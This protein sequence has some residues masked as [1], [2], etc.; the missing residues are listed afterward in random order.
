MNTARCGVTRPLEQVHAKTYPKG[1][2]KNYPLC[3]LS[4]GWVWLGLSIAAFAQEPVLMKAANQAPEFASQHITQNP[5]QRSVMVVLT[6]D[7]KGWVWRG[8]VHPHRRAGGFALLTA[9][10]KRLRKAH[11]DLILLDGGDFLGDAPETEY[12][13]HQGQLPL[14]IEMMQALGY[15]A[16]VLGNRDLARLRLFP[17]WRQQSRVPWLAGNVRAYALSR[18]SPAIAALPFASYVLLNRAG[19]RI[20][21]VGFTQP[22][23]RHRVQ[24]QATQWIASSALPKAAQLVKRMRTQQQ[25]DVVI[26]LIHS[27]VHGH[28][29]REA[30]LR[31]GKA[32]PAEAGLLAWQRSA[33]PQAR[34]D[35]LISAAAHRLHPRARRGWIRPHADYPVPLVEAGAYASQLVMVHIG[36]RRYASP[37]VRTAV[38]S[39][40][41]ASTTAWR[42]MQVKAKALALKLNPTQTVL[43]QVPKPLRAR[44]QRTWRW[45]NTPTAWKIARRPNKR[46]FWACLGGLRHRAVLRLLEAQHPN[47]TATQPATTSPALFT[48]NTLTLLPIPYWLPRAFP[49]NERGLALARKHLYRWMPYPIQ[50][51]KQPIRLDQLRFLVQPYTELLQ[52]THRIALQKVGFIPAGPGLWYSPAKDIRT[53]PK[54]LW[55]KLDTDI[56]PQ[57]STLLPVVTNHH[58]WRGVHGL[59]SRAWLPSP[60]PAQ[61]VHGSLRE[62][63]FHTLRQAKS[64]PNPCHTWLKR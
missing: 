6:G 47:A 59:A 22:G 9:P 25:A 7:V 20:A 26:G 40:T 60:I 35:V 39:K 8:A 21:I 23:Q 63:M 5:K 10:L 13:Q 57:A 34:F 31:Q 24:G 2:R 36:L 27:G 16:A 56:A 29:G 28:Y 54:A 12:A 44:L 18:P 51:I 42:V 62:A 45:L 41:P 58:L 48:Q 43:S 17:H 4:A 14:A 46:T 53:H 50:L 49:K 32:Q 30:S 64:L 61:F 1:H 3:A 38:P 33:L 19:L 55:T 37:V 15:D 11:P 52:K